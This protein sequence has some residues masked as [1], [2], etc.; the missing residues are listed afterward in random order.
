[1]YCPN[2]GQVIADNS[3]TCPTCGAVVNSSAQQQYQ[4][5]YQQQYQQPYQ[6][7]YQQYNPNMYADVY[8]QTAV[9]TINTADTL[10]IVAIISAF[11]IPLACWICAGIGISKVNASNYMAYPDLIVRAESAKKKCKIGIIISIVRF[12]I[13]FILILLPLVFMVP[14]F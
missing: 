14:M 2:C 8:Y 4:P 13:S 3:I 5:Q 1:M 6:Q 12:I 10:G 11:I 7:P 9:S